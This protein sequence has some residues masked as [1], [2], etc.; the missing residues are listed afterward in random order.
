M[1]HRKNIG[2]KNFTRQ[3]NNLQSLQNVLSQ[4]HSINDNDS[5]SD[6]DSNNDNNDVKK[7]NYNNIK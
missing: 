1:S 5:T 2:K 7:I 6:S 3:Y 4:I